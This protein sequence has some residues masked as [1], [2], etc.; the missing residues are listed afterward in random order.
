TVAFHAHFVP[1]LQQLPASVPPGPALVVAQ[2]PVERRKF[3][4][5]LLRIL[6][7]T[8]NFRILPS[9]NAGQT[10]S[11]I[12]KFLP[13]RYREA[14]PFAARRTPFAVTDASYE[15]ALRDG[16]T[17]PSSGGPKPEFYWPEILSFVLR[18]PELA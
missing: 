12:K 16:P 10:P 3:F 9:S 4:E 6:N 18:Q 2:D 7:L 14:T 15:C 8:P 5:E 1:T 17:G 11:A 13:S